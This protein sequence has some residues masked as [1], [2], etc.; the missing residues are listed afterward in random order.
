MSGAIGS[1]ISNVAVY[2]LDLIITRLQ[3]QRQLRKENVDASDQDRDYR[4]IVDAVAKIYRREG[5]FA[6]LYTGVA[7]D[8]G[9]TVVDSFLFF[10]LHNFFRQRRLSKRGPRARS[11]PALDELVVGALAGALTRLITAPIANV[12]TRK[13][14]AAMTALTSSSS[15]RD[16]TNVPSTKAM[17][18]SIIDEK[19]PQGLW[20][21]Y[22]ATL[23]LTLNPSITF[24][25]YEFL[26]RALLP[27]SRRSKPGPRATFLLAAISKAVASTVTYPFSLA[28]TR[29]QVSSRASSSVNTERRVNPG[30]TAGVLEDA[31]DSMKRQARASRKSALFMIFEIVRTEGVQGLYDGLAVEVL[32]G[33]L[34]HGMTMLVKESVHRFIVRTYYLVL[35]ALR[36]YPSPFEMTQSVR[37]KASHASE[38]VTQKT[39]HAVTGLREK[40]TP[41]VSQTQEELRAKAHA[42]YETSRQSIA[43]AKDTAVPVLEKSSKQ[44]QMTARRATDTANLKANEAYNTSAKSVKRASSALEVS[45][46]KATVALS[47]RSIG[48]QS[49]TRQSPQHTN[50]AHTAKKASLKRGTSSLQEAGEQAAAFLKTQADRSQSRGREA[51]LKTRP[52]ANNTYE[53][54]QGAVNAI[55]AV[56]HEKARVTAAAAIAGT[57]RVE[58]RVNRSVND[59]VGTMQK[60]VQPAVLQARELVTRSAETFG[61]SIRRDQKR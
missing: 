53:T 52:S 40:I 41:A 3:V 51:H 54:G 61:R 7:Q 38:D 6:A 8:T 42:G 35:R 43:L 48:L 55:P 50:E 58:D 23:V 30:A 29:A 47:Q 17:I 57:A 18:R 19:G 34:S 27:P 10:W 36:R 37:E 20:S 1:A 16:E 11:L 31:S 9:K 60:N 44:L 33:F 15:Q 14:T 5:G 46:D 49:T 28:K 59:A 45:K 4:G 25:L 22:S 21:G 13:Q 26:K 32:K 12:V 24:F 56:S 39:R 2:P